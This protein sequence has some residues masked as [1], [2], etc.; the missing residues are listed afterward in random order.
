MAKL[1]VMKGVKYT[2]KRLREWLR[3]DGAVVV[4]TKRDEIRCTVHVDPDT[5][6]VAFISA[7]GK[8]LYN[9]DCF[10]QQWMYISEHTGL[11]EFD[12]GVCVNESF[13][14]TKRTVRASKKVYDLNGGIN[15]IDD[16]KTGFY[17]SGQM[18]A[19]FYLY[20]LPT[21]TLPYCERRER[22]ADYAL[23]Y[24]ALRV[25]ET[26]VLT[27]E[28]DVDEYYSHFVKQ[29]H[30][31][32]MVKRIAFDYVYGRTVAWMKMKPEEERDGQIT[33][34][35]AGKGEF[36]G[37]IGSI[38]V[39]FVDGSTTSCSGMSLALRRDITEHPEN[40]TGRIV[41]VRFMERDSQG[42]YRHPRFYRFHPDKT[43]LVGSE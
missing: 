20:D 29:G 21:S 24:P 8:P 37:L 17:F 32:A 31:G 11:R 12:T 28:Y 26:F 13:E 3:D 14:L 41:E 7:Q 10:H 43:T 22:M 33:G 1:Q 5:D 40:Y 27:T 35:T 38:E 4:Q 2:V 16:K 25:P 34:Y 19:L 15:T 23:R 6:T 30:E 42:G 9:L 39:S 36:E 18:Q